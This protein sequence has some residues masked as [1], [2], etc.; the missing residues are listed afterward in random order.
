MNSY[1]TINS[2]K[3][4]SLTKTKNNEEAKSTI[5]YNSGDIASNLNIQ[6]KKIISEQQNNLNAEIKKLKILIN[7]K[8]YNDDIEIQ[9]INSN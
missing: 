3:N 6:V 7:T 9:E 2:K 5:D 8:N 4:D 1:S